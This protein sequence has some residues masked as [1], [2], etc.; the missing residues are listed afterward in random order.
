M[1]GIVCGSASVVFFSIGIIFLV[2]QRERRRIDF[3]NEEFD[4]SNSSD[5]A[6]ESGNK[7]NE[8]NETEVTSTICEYMVSRL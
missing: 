6:Y 2:I 1:L 5:V 4:L 3:M 8:E 7:Q